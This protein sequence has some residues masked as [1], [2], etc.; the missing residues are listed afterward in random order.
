[1]ETPRLQVLKLVSSK[2]ITKF[3]SLGTQSDEVLVAIATLGMVATIADGEADFREIE[4]FEREF[5][6]LFALSRSHSMKL[7]AAAIGLMRLSREL[8][9]I[10]CACDTINEHL[11]SPQKMRLFDGLAEVL[12]ADNKIKDGEEYFLDYIAQRLNLVGYL[13]GAYPSPD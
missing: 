13:E 10:D 7:I 6:K 8:N 12:I 4:T 5:R 9:I 2:P 1:M 11:D 3:T